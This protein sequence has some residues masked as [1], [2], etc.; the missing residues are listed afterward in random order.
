[1]GRILEMGT[2]LYVDECVQ[3]RI[4]LGNI[5]LGR[6]AWGQIVTD[7]NFASKPMQ[8]FKFQTVIFIHSFHIVFRFWSNGV[9]HLKQMLFAYSLVALLWI[10]K[11][12]LKF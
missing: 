2:N 8:C 12:V 9:M 1:M 3:E 5:C 6:I 11:K 7:S 10:S 4:C